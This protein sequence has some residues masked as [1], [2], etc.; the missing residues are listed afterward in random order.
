ML[1]L[2]SSKLIIECYSFHHLWISQASQADGI[3][4][5]QEGVGGRTR[6]EEEKDLR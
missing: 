1:K 6:R 5:I 4:Q 3:R 2:K